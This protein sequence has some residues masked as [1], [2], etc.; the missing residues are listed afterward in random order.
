MLNLLFE[1]HF[2]HSWNP[3]E[4]LFEESSS[5]YAW[6]EWVRRSSDPAIAVHHLMTIMQIAHFQTLSTEEEKRAIEHFQSLR[7]SLDGGKKTFD[8]I[9]SALSYIL[10]T[11]SENNPKN[12]LIRYAME[13][14]MSLHSSG[15]KYSD[16]LKALIEEILKQVKTQMPTLQ[17]KV[18]SHKLQIFYEGSQ[19][20]EE[21]EKLKKQLWK[22]Y[23]S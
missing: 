16:E 5:F 17:A 19:S 3:G 21:I 9:P 2:N 8:Q 10:D 7:D 20:E 14:E 12:R 23:H 4:K 6:Y 11:L 13:I 18:I 1:P 15:R 22:L